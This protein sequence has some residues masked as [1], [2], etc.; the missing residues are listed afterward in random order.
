MS[1]RNG[2]CGFTR[3]SITPRSS[4][5]G[6][7]VI[8]CMSQVTRRPDGDGGDDRSYLLP[9]R[10]VSAAFMTVISLLEIQYC[11]TLFA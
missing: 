1:A 6:L 7:I 4:P 3:S 2:S 10:T 9:L 5:V 11:S 8:L